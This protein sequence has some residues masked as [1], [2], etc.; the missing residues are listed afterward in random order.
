MTLFSNF[1]II[2]YNSPGYE[3]KM[4]ENIFWARYK[5]QY[6]GFFGACLKLERFVCCFRGNILGKIKTTIYNGHLYLAQNISSKYFLK[7]KTT[8][9]NG[10]LIFR[11]SIEQLII[12]K[13]N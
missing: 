9:Y 11:Y 12:T 10:S 7:I 1:A 5:L 6:V 3:Q 2:P 8:I 4:A 13:Y